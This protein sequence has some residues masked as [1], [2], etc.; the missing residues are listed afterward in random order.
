MERL[1]VAVRDGEVGQ[2][3]LLQRLSGRRQAGV[4]EQ[5]RREIDRRPQTMWRLKNGFPQASSRPGDQFS[6]RPLLRTPRLPAAGEAL[7]QVYLSHLAVPDDDGQRSMPSLTPRSAEAHRR[8]HALALLGLA[9]RHP[10]ADWLRR[11]YRPREYRAWLHLVHWNGA[12]KAQP[13]ARLPD[14]ACLTSR[15]RSSDATHHLPAAAL[16]EGFSADA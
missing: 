7:Q 9:T 15:S 5:R 10:L 2:I 3:D 11:H 1:A 13:D 4:A 14:A 16:G 6:R 8:G 12:D